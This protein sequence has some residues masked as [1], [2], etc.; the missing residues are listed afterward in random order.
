MLA[1]RDV[2]QLSPGN[3]FLLTICSLKSAYS[4]WPL[5]S[6]KNKW[7][8]IT[9]LP[10]YPRD[11]SQTSLFRINK[12]QYSPWVKYYKVIHYWILTFFSANWEMYW[13]YCG[14]SS[15]YDI[16]TWYLMCKMSEIS[17]KQ[18]DKQTKTI[19]NAAVRQAWLRQKTK[20]GFPLIDRVHLVWIKQCC[21]SFSSVLCLNFENIQVEL[22]KATFKSKSAVLCTVKIFKLLC[23]LFY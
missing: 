9:R 3:R 21:G 10:F 16:I 8:S 7:L 14:K 4:A 5:T 18:T 6:D 11:D 23:F 20:K 12:P 13:N 19:D 1:F 15:N 2:L 17:K 22:L